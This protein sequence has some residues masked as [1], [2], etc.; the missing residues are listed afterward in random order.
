MIKVFNYMKK[1]CYLD[2]KCSVMFTMFYNFLLDLYHFREKTKT[3]NRFLTLNMLKRFHHYKNFHG[4]FSTHIKST[5][6][7]GLNSP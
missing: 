6:W 2:W 7:N 5:V 3:L 1:H 4:C